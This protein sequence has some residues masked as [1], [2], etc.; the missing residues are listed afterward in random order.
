M[1]ADTNYKFPTK[2]VVPT[3]D[4]YTIK[5]F[6]DSVD[7]YLSNDT[8]I[9]Y[10]YNDGI[11]VLANAR[12]ILGQNIPNPAKD[13]TRIDYSIP[14]DGQVIFTVYTVTGQALHIEKRDSYS[15]DNHIEFNTINLAS[16]V[17]YYSM[18][19]KGERLVKKMTIRK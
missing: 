18:E 1:G 5:V 4:Y 14:T 8:V 12:F 15:G 6:I 3:E 2:D 19:Y 13:N 7:K 11:I 17:Y 16:G 10:C 9:E